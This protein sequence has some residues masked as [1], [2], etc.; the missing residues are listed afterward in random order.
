MVFSILSK[1][2]DGTREGTRAALQGVGDISG[3]I[4]GQLKM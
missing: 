4:L 2:V 1:V 3:A